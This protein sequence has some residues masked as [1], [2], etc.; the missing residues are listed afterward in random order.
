MKK[1]DVTVSNKNT[2]VLNENAVA[3]DYIDL[4]TISNLDLTN[5]ERLID[6]G[7]DSIFNKKINEYQE[8]ARKLQIEAEKRLKM[9]FEREHL[10]ILNEKELSYQELLNKFNSLKETQERLIEHEKLLISRQFEEEISSL[11]EQLIKVELSHQEQL[12]KKQEE[13]NTINNMYLQL[14]NQKAQLNVK[15]I[16][17]SLE[18]DCNNEVLSYMQNG[19]FNCTWEKDN[20]V[21]KEEGDSKGSKA[22]FIFKVYASRE[23]LQEELLTSVCLEMK[24]ENPDSKHKKTNA[25]Y[26]LQLNNNRHKKNAKYAVLVSNLETDNNS[27]LP[28]Y[29]VSEYPD[30]Y[31]VRPSYLMT[32]LNMIVSLTERF[33]DLILANKKEQ[34]ELQSQLELEAKFEELKKKYLE[35]PL[36]RLQTKIEEIKKENSNILKAVE[37]SN[38]ICEHIINTYIEGI[39]DK[40]EKFEININREYKKRNK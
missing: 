8:Q 38:I 36:N 11:K 22:D 34:L 33:S 19:L 18:I 21:V 13:Y 23:H 17:E 40:L 5:I 16:G 14:K 1:L 9:E 27:Y 6:E 3:G 37:K 25:D 20:K 7:K 32:F 26:Y 31:V 12:L 24:D 39:L 15:L 4:S 35:D 29:K 10:K 2:I 28:I 30:M